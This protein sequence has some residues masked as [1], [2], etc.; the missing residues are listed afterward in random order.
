MGNIFS[1]DSAFYKIGTEVADWMI[2][3]LYWLVGCLPILTIGASTTAAFYVCG[4]KVRGEDYYLTRDFVKSFKENFKQSLPVT[5]IFLVAWFSGSMYIYLLFLQPEQLPVAMLSLSLFA[6]V[7]IALFTTYV[8]SLLSRFHMKTKDLFATSFI[9][10]HKHFLTSFV[11]IISMIVILLIGIF[12][13]MLLL[14]VPVSYILLSSYFVQKVFKKN[15]IFQAANQN[16]EV[17]TSDEEDTESESFQD[18]IVE[19]EKEYLKYV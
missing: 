16:G 11:L 7:E 1:M 12:I 13:P 4:K 14:F 10:I 6:V 3:G 5:L 2:L 9:L 17:V 18:M 19:E 15:L 8:F